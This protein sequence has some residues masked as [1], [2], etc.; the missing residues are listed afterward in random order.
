MCLSF[1]DRSGKGFQKFNKY[2]IWHS[3]RFWLVYR[4]SYIGLWQ[5]PISLDSLSSPIFR[6]FGAPL[7]SLHLPQVPLQGI[8]FFFGVCE[9]YRSIYS[10][11][12]KP[13]K[14]T[15]E[16]PSKKNNHFFP[17]EPATHPHPQP[18]FFVG[19]EKKIRKKNPR[20]RKLAKTP[21]P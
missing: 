9:L 8:C 12:I 17:M 14:N 13:K 10:T 1:R 15:R 4:D 7:N 20:L 3:M 5:S 2:Q 19:T 11:H 16:I 18:V 21:L 6:F